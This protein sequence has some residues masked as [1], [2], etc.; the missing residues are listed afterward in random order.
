VN[1]RVSRYRVARMSVFPPSTEGGHAR[2]CI[3]AHRIRNG[4]PSGQI[5]LDGVLPGA[6]TSPTTEE[7]LALFDSALRQNMLSAQ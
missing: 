1:D 4:I 2:Y 5:L 6:P 3:V 7:L